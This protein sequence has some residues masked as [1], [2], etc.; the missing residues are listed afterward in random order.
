MKSI[1][2]LFLL[3]NEVLFSAIY[4]FIHFHTNILFIRLSKNGFKFVRGMG[5]ISGVQQFDA[6]TLRNTSI[7]KVR[8]NCKMILILKFILRKVFRWIFQTYLKINL[9]LEYLEFIFISKT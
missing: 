4:S 1:A 2:L 3:F 6:H 9:K 5:K 7:Y 8:I